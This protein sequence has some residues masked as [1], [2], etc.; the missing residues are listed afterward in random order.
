MPIKE[1]MQFPFRSYS[2][3]V[4][5]QVYAV[6]N[7]E[8]GKGRDC[9]KNTLLVGNN[10]PN[11]YPKFYNDNGKRG[12]RVW[13]KLAQFSLR[14]QSLSVFNQVDKFDTWIGQGLTLRIL[15]L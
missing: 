8:I 7:I 3:S 1:K 15:Y 10:Y 14:L 9:S 12:K 4:F 13:M 11:A 2:L 5:D 6:D